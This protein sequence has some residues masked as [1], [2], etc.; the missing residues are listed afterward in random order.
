MGD[1]AKSPKRQIKPQ[2]VRYHKAYKR[3]IMWRQSHISIFYACNKINHFKDASELRAKRVTE[4]KKREHPLPK[5]EPSSLQDT[6][7]FKN[8]D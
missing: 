4:L 8:E 5:I 3:Y 7:V 6:P 2:Y 1:L